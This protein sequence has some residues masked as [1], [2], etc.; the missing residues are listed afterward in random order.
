MC[1]TFGASG[2]QSRAVR[3]NSD[4][5][6]AVWT[7]V[8]TASGPD[9]M[10]EAGGVAIGADGHP[11]MAFTQCDSSGANCAIVAV[12]LNGTTGAQI[13]RRASPAGTTFDFAK[14]VAIGPDRPS[15]RRR[16]NLQRRQQQLPGEGVQGQRLD[17]RRDLQRHARDELPDAVWRRDSCEQQQSFC[18]RRSVR[19]DFAELQHRHVPAQRHDRRAG[20]DDHL[21]RRRASRLLQRN[22]LGRSHRH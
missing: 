6:A 4:T 11:V 2:C 21:Q 14:G 12:K 5:G 1:S 13:W 15:R 16:R 3:Y 20:V 9:A 22:R 18:D 7:F 19:R 8:D 10:A 17:R